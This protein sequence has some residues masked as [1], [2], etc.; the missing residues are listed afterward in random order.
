M[1]VQSVEA[2]IQNSMAAQAAIDWYQSRLGF[3]CAGNDVI[4]GPM[5]AELFQ[6]TE[7]I[8]LQRWILRLGEEILQ[9]WGWPPGACA[10]YPDSWG[11][12]DHW[13]QHICLV[14]DDL[15]SRVQ[16]LAPDQLGVISSAP[17]RL[18]DWNQAAA[19]IEA[20]KFKD[21]EGHP[22]ELLQFP[23]DKGDPRWHQDHQLDGRPKGFDHSAISIACTDESLAFYRDVLGFHVK[24]QCV[25]SGIEQDQMDGLDNTRVAITALGPQS[26]AM[27]VE[28][29]NYQSPTGG[30]NRSSPLWSDLCDRKLLLK[31]KNLHGLHETL[32]PRKDINFCSPIVPLEP[33]LFGAPY[34]FS[35]RDP[36]QHSIVLVGDAS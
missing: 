2:V 1:T 27:G 12:N 8:S 4:S 23:P 22:L 29:L 24:G 34:G 16:V 21:P 26:G 19:G 11:G 35:V 15:T 18:P 32:I 30:R 25:N 36:D 17:Q 9:I 10:P 31:A 7:S 5:L 20:F 3:V 6:W 13:F 33:S 14:T 28:F